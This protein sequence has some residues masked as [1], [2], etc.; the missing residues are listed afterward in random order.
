M[1]FTKFFSQELSYRTPYHRM[2]SHKVTKVV[3]P[4]DLDVLDLLIKKTKDFRLNSIAQPGIFP[5]KGSFLEKGHFNK[6]SMYEYKIRVP[7]RNNL[8]V[9][10]QDTFKTLF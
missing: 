6:R 1:N 7:Q 2:I 5:V 8:E 10:H 4:Q 9:F 3:H